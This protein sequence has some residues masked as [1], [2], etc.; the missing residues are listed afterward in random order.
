MKRTY[1]KPETETLAVSAEQS[2]LAGSSFT[3]GVADMGESTDDFTSLSNEAKDIDI[4]E[5]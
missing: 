5:E 1:I 4:W 3:I 2:L